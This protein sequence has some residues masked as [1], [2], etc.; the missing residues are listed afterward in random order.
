[1]SG[2]ALGPL[3][4]PPPE[5]HYFWIVVLLPA[6][7]AIV[8]LGIALVRGRFPGGR[9]FGPGI[10]AAAFL[11][12]A[13]A[14]GLGAIHLAEEA[15][16]VEFCGSCH[17]T[18]PPLVASLSSDEPSLAAF[19]FQQG[20]VSRVEAC[21]TCHSGYGIW[22]TVAAKEAGFGHMW[23]TLTGDYHLPLQHDGP[24]D[25]AACL[26]CHAG[27]KPFRDVEVHRDPDLGKALLDGEMGCT[28]D[29]HL[30]AHPESALH[31]TAAATS[32]AAGGTR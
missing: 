11:L 21:Y 22:G 1:M 24:F 27:T 12:P 20:A 7:L 14:Y 5:V 16:R 28:G 13:F 8:V 30:V 25:I 15:K 18:M 31:G 2:E 10:A 6:L 4:M 9:R 26:N 32:A 29:C 17:A 23:R 3:F 19:H